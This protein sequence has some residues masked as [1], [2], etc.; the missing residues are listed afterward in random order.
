MKSNIHSK[1]LQKIACILMECGR[2][3]VSSTANSKNQQL[4]WHERIARNKVLKRKVSIKSGASCL[5]QRRGC[6]FD[7]DL[8]CCRHMSV[9]LIRWT[10]KHMNLSLLEIGCPTQIH[11]VFSS[12]LYMNHV[13]IEFISKSI[14]GRLPQTGRHFGTTYVRTKASTSGATSRVPLLP[15]R[16]C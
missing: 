3:L 11:I 13:Y 9:A 1:G 10:H 6:F 8:T 2:H 16:R 5:C 7:V 4:H 12:T 14:P 15:W